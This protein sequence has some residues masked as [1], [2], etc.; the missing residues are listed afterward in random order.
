MAISNQTFS[1]L[2]KR[3]GRS[4]RVTSLEEWINKIRKGEYTGKCVA[5]T[6]DDGYRDNY[7]QAKDILM[8]ACLPATF[9]IPIRHIENSEPYWWDYLFSVIQR[10]GS[11]FR[12]WIRSKQ[13]PQT[14]HNFIDSNFDIT[15]NNS[16]GLARAMVKCLNRVGY[17]QRNAFLTALQNE[18][19]PYEAERLLMN[20]SEIKQ[21]KREGFSI[22]SHSVSH[23]PLTDLPNNKA[24]EEIRNSKTI[25]SQKL[26]S[27]INGF[28]YPRGK[29]NEFLATAV[30]KAGY[31]YAVTTQ[32]GSNI[33]GCNLFALSRR[34]MADYHG[35]RSYFSVAMHMLELSGLLDRVLASRR[36][37][38]E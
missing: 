3:L 15:N 26:K 32:F 16:N 37:E 33:R 9:F 30:E 24:L 18:F 10:E 7:E 13:L 29:W 21:L 35:I 23:V 8:R 28:C 4:N 34:N 11:G 20:W 14:T 17:E 12:S 38:K 19:G 6:F 1:K 27:E 25:L 2:I 31:Q 36:N 5:F 22:G